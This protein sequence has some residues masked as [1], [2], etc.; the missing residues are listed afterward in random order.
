M[1]GLSLV[2]ESRG[3]SLVAVL[4]LVAVA[5]RGAQAVGHVGFAS[6]SVWAR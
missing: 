1:L 4:G 5:S 2:V 3:D 6:C